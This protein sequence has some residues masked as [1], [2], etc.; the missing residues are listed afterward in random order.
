MVTIHFTLTYWQLGI[1][2]LW[3]FYDGFVTY[4]G[5]QEAIKNRDWAIVA[6]S[7]PIVIPAGII[8]V[9]FNQTFGRLMFLEWTNTF[10]F[11]ERLDYHY[12]EMSWRGSMARSIGNVINKVF[13]H[14]T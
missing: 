11:S 10:T 1:L 7:L 13:K 9:V 12:H 2:L 3:I 6:P 5:L 8:D 14:I 4:A